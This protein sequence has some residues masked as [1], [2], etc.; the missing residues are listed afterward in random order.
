MQALLMAARSRTG[1]WSYAHVGELVWEFFVMSAHVD[2]RRHVRL[3]FDGNHRL[4]GYAMLAEGPSFQVQVAP[5][6]TG[7]GMEDEALGWALR[8]LGELRVEDPPNWGGALEAGARRS[9]PDRIDWLRRRGF[10]LRGTFSEVNLLRSLRD[11][12][13]KPE[14]PAG[15]EVREVADRGEDD[16]RAGAQSEVWQPWPVG[17]IGGADYRRLMQL[18]GYDRQL[19]VVTASSGGVIAAYVN[20]WADPVNGIGDL[21]PVGARPAFRRRGLTRAALLEGL[22]RLRERGM[23]R[24]AVSTGVLN[25]AAR[26]LYESIGFQ[27]SDEYLDFVADPPGA[28]ERE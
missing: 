28:A 27:P 7:S 24:A 9:D 10:R 15:F 25:V 4:S 22:R 2:P 8:L 17:R 3:W 26:R 5:V 20:G 11:P 6:V 18:P 21:G 19:D 12:V 1:E 14:V 23:D 13:P 16:E